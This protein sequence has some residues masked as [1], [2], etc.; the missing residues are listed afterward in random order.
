MY[1]SSY[2]YS[3][4]PPRVS[5]SINHFIT[6]TIQSYSRVSHRTNQS[7]AS[8]SPCWP[9]LCFPSTK[10][11][12]PYRHISLLTI[13]NCFTVPFLLSFLS[14]LNVYYTFQCST[15]S[16]LSHSFALQSLFSSVVRYCPS[17]FSTRTCPLHPKSLP[18]GYV[19]LPLSYLLLFF[20]TSTFTPFC[21]ASTK[22]CILACQIACFANHDFWSIHRTKIALNINRKHDSHA[23][24]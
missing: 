24:S 22:F 19:V 13:C 2:S 8:R 20:A 15:Y 16:E 18:L 14:S 1:L 9:V 11:W 10:A 4:C 12:S 17:T 23:V 7:I 6:A 5:Y 21:S 3:L